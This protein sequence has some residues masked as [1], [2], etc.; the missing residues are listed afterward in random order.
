MRKAEEESTEAVA[1]VKSA[2]GNTDLSV[3]YQWDEFDGFI[4][5]NNT[6]IAE[7]GDKPAFV[8]AYA[9]RN[10]LVVLEVL[11]K[12]CGDPDYKEELAKLTTIKVSPNAAFDN[13]DSSFELSENGDAFSVNI[14]S[15][16]YSRSADD[17]KR[18]IVN[19]W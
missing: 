13:N 19:V 17:F 15:N 18:D 14:I 4:A 7:K 3:S 6:V 11:G 12:L 9:N 16:A 10:L 8:Y 5:A 1:L 2:C